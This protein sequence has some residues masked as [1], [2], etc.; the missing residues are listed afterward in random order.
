M[1]TKKTT[2][3]KYLQD[4]GLRITSDPSK[5]YNSYN[6][7]R[8]KKPWGKRDLMEYGI[9][10]D[11]YCGGYHRAYDMSLKHGA[12]LR[13]VADALVAPG[14]GWNTFGW[15]L[16][17]TFFDATGKQYQ[18][19]Y[20]HLNRNPLGY[21]KLGQTVKQGDIVA[22]QGRSNNIGVNN[23]ASHLHI[24]FQ[25]FGALSAKP[26][27]CNGIDPLNIDV[28]KTHPTRS[29]VVSDS[30]AMIIDVS[31]H[32]PSKSINYK[33]LSKHVD[34]VI[35]RTMDAD[36]ID[37]AY[38]THHTEFRKYGVPTAAYAFF[39][40]QNN[41]HVRN[42]AKMFW[43]RTK[44]LN[45]TFWWIDVETSPHSNMRAAVTMYINELRKHGA[46]KV[47]LYIAHHL[48]K[49]LNLDTSKADAVWIP[50][51]GTGSSKPDS[52]PAFPADIHQYTEHGRLPG[53]NSNLDLNRIISNKKLEFFTDGKKSKKKPS[54]LAPSKPKK[55]TKPKSNKITGSTYT[56]KSGDNLSTI[57]SRAGTTTEK[58]QNLNNIPD[59]NTIFP[60][61]K[62]K[63]KGSATS[64]YTVKSGDT[65][66]GIASMY[67]TKTR[68]LQ[69]L[70][71]IPNPNRIYVGQKITLP[72]SAKKST[73]QYH[74]VKSGDTVSY[75]AQRY[76]SSQSQIVRWNNLRNANEI[77]I[78]DSLRVK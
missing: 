36:M 15:T 39:R 30:N 44:D 38:Q 37:R 45:P 76:G 34:H 74:T 35:I 11:S 50:H 21:L 58:L 16:V 62:L 10:A 65:L 32:Q 78:N 31:H 41:T 20:G 42:E 18:V 24:Q 53:Y 19:I 1:L 3:I 8:G 59:P 22:Y 61:Q 70:N 68:T 23:M 13:S 12:G 54:T 4:K 67:N 57:A 69:S 14:T 47:G 71:D 60:G 27:T 72:G 49:Q 7:N 28:S 52:T 29:P 56:V 55:E 33:E 26:F 40:A 43:D 17:L 75:L 48:Y 9:N 64:T 66:S 77:Y 25:N 63:L 51:Y 46:K 73:K 5:Y 6:P 2:P